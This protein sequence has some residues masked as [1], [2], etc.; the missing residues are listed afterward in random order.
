M[1]G[2]TALL[3][4]FYS[5]SVFGQSNST[6]NFIIS[7]F[8][9]PETVEKFNTISLQM[10]LVNKVAG[11]NVAYL[12]ISVTIIISTG[13][14]FYLF[15]VKP[16]EEKINIQEKELEIQKKANLEKLEKLASSVEKAQKDS[17][18]KLMMMKESLTVLIEGKVTSAEKKV[19]SLENLAKKE[20]A[21]MKSNA[22][23]LELEGLWNKQ[24]IWRVGQ[25]K[26][27]VNTLRSL[28]EF[29]EAQIRY[30][31]ESATTELA[32]SNISDT[33]DLLKNEKPLNGDKKDRG[34][35]Y[36]RLVNSLSKIKG[37]DSRKNGLLEKAKE[38]LLLE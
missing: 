7:N 26:V 6:Q 29:L 30:N 3:A 9:T 20:I 8:P 2:L 15:S 19:E 21:D 35:L 24:Y 37:Y 33:L 4:F 27:P 32:F 12:A 31:I 13:V 18:E 16:L 36:D 10:D 25:T 1:K 38:V 28:V 22:H 5:S 17:E 34:Q 23:A 14:L 11:Y